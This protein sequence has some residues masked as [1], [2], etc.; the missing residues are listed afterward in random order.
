MM[1]YLFGLGL[2]GLFLQI[3]CSANVTTD[4]AGSIAESKSVMRM[5]TASDSMMMPNTAG[6]ELV[7][8]GQG[9]GMGGDKFDHI[10]ENDFDLVSA[11]PLSTFSID[12]DTA[13]YSKTRMFIEQMGKLPPSDAVRIEEFVNYFD[14]DYK[15]P[16]ATSEHPFTVDVE[17]AN[18]P[19]KP[20]HKL[21]RIGIK[22]YEIEH[23]E[24]PLS[25][26]VFL[27]DVSGS[28]RQPNK[29]GLLKQGLKMLVEQLGAR[30]RV[31]MVV[32]AGASGVVL[33]PT[34]GSEQATI[35]GALDRLRAGG[36]TN[37]GAGIELAYRLAEENFITDGTN[38]IVLCT[39]GDFNVGTTSTGALVRLA[40][41]HAKKN[42]FISV[43]G[44][45]TG[46]HNDAMMEE[47][48]NKANGN[49]AF[50]D[51][52]QEAHRVLVEKIHANMMTIAKDVKI[53]I[54]FNPAQVSAYRLIGY[55]NRKLADRDFNDDKKDAG[56]IGAGHTVT[57]LYEIVPA[58]VEVG[59]LA[60][61]DPLKYQTTQVSQSSNDEAVAT[62]AVS[63][64]GS[65][66]LMTV[67]LRYKQPEGNK[68]VLLAVPVT[69]SSD[70]SF[71]TASVDFRFA[72]SVAA[73]GMKLRDSKYIADATMQDL[74]GWARQSLGEDEYGYR[75]ECL[76]LMRTAARLMN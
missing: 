36:S 23:A 30:D 28:M 58:G 56:E 24:R 33:P 16:N 20:Q 9:P 17:L 19:W 6:A 54:E 45:G 14:Y 44:F 29:L 37:G 3:G 34:P 40:A 22:G 2:L 68:S 64:T 42:I 50:I 18:C 74:A 48:S 12:V 61:V 51:S 53:Q 47:L 72:T 63:T 73:F 55:E 31:S 43:M 62:A 4:N 25:N 52:P 59:N 26:F 21:A 5:P 39:D 70:R 35:L 67:Q 75:T 11:S 46:N 49:Y 15:T 66:E 69:D 38:R 65:D 71:E 1:R 7:A 32:Y 27:L 10:I 57:A 13:S 41:D 76:G 8:E 60:D